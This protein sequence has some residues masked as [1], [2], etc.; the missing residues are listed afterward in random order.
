MENKGVDVAGK[1]RGDDRS[2]YSGGES[3]GRVSALL[4]SKAEAEWV[5]ITA[6]IRVRPCER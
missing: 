2:A 3:E 5:K 6:V 1:P 4:Q